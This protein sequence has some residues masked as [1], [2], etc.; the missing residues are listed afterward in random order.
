M[1]V[2]PFSEFFLYP[3]P[4]C[5]LNLT[6]TQYKF[7]ASTP[8]KHEIYLQILKNSFNAEYENHL[9][10]RVCKSFLM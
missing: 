7:S 1:P 4:S 10:C 8:R 9:Q 2:L 6:F 5:F 3:S